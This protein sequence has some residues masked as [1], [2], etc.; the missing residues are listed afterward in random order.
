MGSDNALKSTGSRDESSGD[1][2]VAA[3]L[4]VVGRFLFIC[5]IMQM[6]SARAIPFKGGRVGRGIRISEGSQA[7]G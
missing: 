3:C 6:I 5:V 7:V 4:G 1:R 2:R